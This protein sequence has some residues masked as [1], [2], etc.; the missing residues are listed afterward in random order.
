VDQDG[1]VSS[2]CYL[3]CALYARLRHAI[4]SNPT[5][6]GSLGPSPHPTTS[7]SIIALLP[8]ES[9]PPLRTNTS[10]VHINTISSNPSAHC[11]HNPVHLHSTTSRSV[12]FTALLG[13]RIIDNPA[14]PV[15]ELRLCDHVAGGVHRQGDDSS[16]CSMSQQAP[17]LSNV[18]RLKNKSLAWNGGRLRCTDWSELW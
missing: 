11:L 1:S 16:L 9:S 2:T 12:P 5:P 7:P 17:K 14:S 6:E 18:V 15:R 10:G 3:P 13:N 4:Y 8:Q